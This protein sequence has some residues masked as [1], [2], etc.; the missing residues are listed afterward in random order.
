MHVSCLG[1]DFSQELIPYDCFIYPNL[2]CLPR[3]ASE[4]TKAEDSL[5][6]IGL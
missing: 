4:K 3:T 5:A 6:G 2:I 1:L